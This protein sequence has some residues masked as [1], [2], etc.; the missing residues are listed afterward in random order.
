VTH[1][2]LLVVIPAR[3]ASTRFPGKPLVKLKGGNGTARTLIEWTWQAAVAAVGADSVI[4]ATDDNR[5]IGEVSRFGGTAVLTPSD[6][7]NG[8][9]RCAFHIDTMAVKPRFILNFQGDAPL[10]P[11]EFVR[12]LIKFGKA[13]GS[14]MATPFVSC[15]EKMSSVLRKEAAVG[16]AGG[17]C[18]VTDK[19][20]RALYFS[21]YPIPFGA[22]APLKMH[23]GLYVYTSE[24]LAHYL[25]IPP[26]DAELTEGL[27]QLRF[28]DAG[29]GIDMLELP[30]PRTGL[31]ELNN[32]EDIAIIESALATV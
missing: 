8:T 25:Q 19:N 27:E 26:S 4:V 13:K 16:R 24:A 10:I 30:L 23:I 28:L 5:I 21:K 12:T 31:W 32:P 11:A 2:D 29:I 18:V 6:L 9:E 20:G 17:T 15:D 1:D 14:M 7:R 3:F 22:N